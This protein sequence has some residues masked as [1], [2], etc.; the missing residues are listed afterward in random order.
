[1]QSSDCAHGVFL[2]GEEINHAFD[3]RHR[4][5]IHLSGHE[6]MRGLIHYLCPQFLVFLIR[7]QLL[8][9][10]LKIFQRREG[11]DVRRLGFLPV[12]Q[13]SRTFFGDAHQQRF[14]FPA[15]TSDKHE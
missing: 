2:F 15:G 11:T 4:L 12:Q 5:L 13:Y 7:R 14:I 3:I 9:R 10:I 6:Q 1:M 8:Q